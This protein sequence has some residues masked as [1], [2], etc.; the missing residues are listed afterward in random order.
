[1]I[2]SFWVCCFAQVL[3][4]L[5]PSAQFWNNLNYCVRRNLTTQIMGQY[6]YANCLSLVS[7]LPLIVLVADSR[8]LGCAIP[9]PFCCNRILNRGVV[10]KG[11]F[12]VLQKVNG[13]KR[14]ELSAEIFLHRA[15]VHIPRREAH[16]QMRGGRIGILVFP[17]VFF[18]I[19]FVLFVGLLLGIYC[20]WWWRRRYCTSHGLVATTAVVSTAT[21]HTH[22]SMCTPWMVVSIVH[23]VWRGWWRWQSTPPRI[24]QMLQ[25]V[26]APFRMRA[27]I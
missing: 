21:I 27:I 4:D 15:K 3:L 9:P 13:K 20:H 26:V 24:F 12:L 10:H 19:F 18:S 1:M 5:R 17:H 22:F 16:P 11:T 14:F 8:I 23:S 7:S 6:P 2:L 25:S